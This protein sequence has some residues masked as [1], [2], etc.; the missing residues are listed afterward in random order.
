MSGPRRLSQ[1]EAWLGGAKGQ[2]DHRYRHGDGKTAADLMPEGDPDE[3]A[4]PA[5]LDVAGK[6][7]WRR[8]IAAAPPG[9]LHK[10]NTD[11]VTALPAAVARHENAVR[12]LQR[13]W[14]DRDDLALHFAIER[15]AL[16]A[17]GQVAELATALGLSPIARSR[18]ALP[19]PE[20]E[21]AFPDSP[22]LRVI[23]FIGPDGK[24]RRAS[25]A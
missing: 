3:N 24:R 21:P 6:K 20:P 2:R 5:F 4:P 8:I 14:Q 10:I 23:Q 15:N 12:L 17:A 22:Q 11:L 16:R 13:V 25:S 18:I 19:A 7:A 1:K 9:L